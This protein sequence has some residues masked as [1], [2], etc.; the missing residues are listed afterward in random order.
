M[1]LP[2]IYIYHPPEGIGYQ[3]LLTW[4]AEVEQMMR[5]DAKWDRCDVKTVC[6]TDQLGFNIATEVRRVKARPGPVVFV[7]KVQRKLYDSFSGK[8]SRVARVYSIEKPTQASD[9]F[10]RC[11]DALSDFEGGEPR[12]S[13]RELIAFLIVAKLARGDYWAGDARNKA[14]LKASDL[15]NGGFPK[16]VSKGEV[17]NAV[18]A[19]CNSGVV[20]H[21]LG[22]GEKK[23]GLS[24]KSTVEEILDS[25]SFPGNRKLEKWFQRGNETVPAR[26]LNGNYG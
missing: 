10:A 9:I 23:Y 12:I 20:G 24:T 13:K 16:Y 25:K 8:L 4:F 26:D 6:L 21:K 22:G 3:Y 7:N 19:L 15:P 18:N 5:A 17:L 11:Q 14:F 2:R 1:P